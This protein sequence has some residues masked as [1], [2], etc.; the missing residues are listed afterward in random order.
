VLLVIGSSLADLIANGDGNE[1]GELGSGSSTLGYH[2]GNGL[3]TTKVS[4][5]RK[6]LIDS[7]KTKAD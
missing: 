4:K 5:L 2:V 1:R 3:P 6:V 7:S